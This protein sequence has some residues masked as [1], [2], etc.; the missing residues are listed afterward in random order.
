MACPGNLVLGL[1]IESVSAGPRATI[2]PKRHLSRQSASLY[3][4]PC[5]RKGCIPGQGLLFRDI[6]SALAVETLDSAVSIRQEF[7]SFVCLTFLVY[8]HVEGIFEP[9]SVRGREN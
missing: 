3:F 2:S 1:C 4:C 7:S 9:A 8:V 6:L 5:R